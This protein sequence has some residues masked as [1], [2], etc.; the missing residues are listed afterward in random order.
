MVFVALDGDQE[1]ETRFTGVVWCPDCVSDGNDGD[2]IREDLNA[3]A[4]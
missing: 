1:S 3:V 4:Q 2:Q